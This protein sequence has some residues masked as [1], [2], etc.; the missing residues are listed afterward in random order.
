MIISYYIRLTASFIFSLLFSL[1]IISI[2]QERTYMIVLPS[3]MGLLSAMVL[4]SLMCSMLEGKKYFFK[5]K[6]LNVRL[7]AIILICLFILTFGILTELFLGHYIYSIII[8]AA[9][10]L[11]LGYTFADWHVL[12]YQSVSSKKQIIIVALVFIFGQYVAIALYNILSAILNFQQLYNASIIVCFIFSLV[13][14]ILTYLDSFFYAKNDLEE[15]EAIVINNFTLTQL[16]LLLLIILSA[17][18]MFLLSIVDYCYQRNIYEN[19]WVS[20]F[21]EIGI[22]WLTVI[23]VIFFLCVA[24]FIL[25]RYGQKIFIYC[26][27]ISALLALFLFIIAMITSFQY[28]FLLYF[29]AFFAQGGAIFM[30]IL[31]NYFVISFFTSGIIRIFV[32][33]TTAIL[34]FFM[35][36]YQ[37]V[38]PVFVVLSVAN[39]DLIWPV[40]SIVL[41]FILILF[42]SRMSLQSVKKAL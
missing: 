24:V 9:F 1:F 25:K 8:S 18:G 20:S 7:L 22:L 26:A 3:I 42:S 17:Q 6:T 40:I 32:P 31:F 4:G 37:S 27:E 10:G 14:I 34:L 11:L 21:N 5:K 29:C 39:N 12:L 38:I 30:F 28:A 16:Q 36:L 15:D 2:N 41:I 19:Q 35:A 33:I 23:S 13:L